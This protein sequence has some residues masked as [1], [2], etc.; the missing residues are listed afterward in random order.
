M[1]FSPSS[2]HKGWKKCNPKI[3]KSKCQQTKAFAIKPFHV[4]VPFAFRFVSSQ[5]QTAGMR[6]DKCVALH[7]NSNL[8]LK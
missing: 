8:E 4:K 3:F 6:G 2:Q 1:L 5:K 7:L